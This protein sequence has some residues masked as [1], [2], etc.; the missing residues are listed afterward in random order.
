MLQDNWDGAPLAVDNYNIFLE[1]M[2]K[3]ASDVQEELAG[4]KGTMQARKRL[5]SKS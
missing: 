2:T 5:S 1:D 4:I 3:C